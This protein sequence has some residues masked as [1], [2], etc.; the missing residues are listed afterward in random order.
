MKAPTEFVAALLNRDLTCANELLSC[1][2]IN[3]G[4][5]PSGWTALHYVVEEGI[6]KSA[7]WL[8]QH[9][10]DPNRKDSTGWTALHLAV[11]AEADSALQ[12]SVREGVVVNEFN[13]TRLLLDHGANPLAPSK[14]GQTPISIASDYGRTELVG[15]LKGSTTPE[16]PAD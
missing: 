15:I 8:L 6:L 3:L 12:R 4:F 5:P 13:L 1:T 14:N 7:E 16:T 2:E 11:D 9:G 10:A